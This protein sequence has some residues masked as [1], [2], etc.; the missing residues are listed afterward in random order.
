MKM[1]G[2]SLVRNTRNSGESLQL[3]IAS[4]EIIPSTPYRKSVDCNHGEHVVHSGGKYGSYLLVPTIAK[5]KVCIPRA[6]SGLM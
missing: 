6:C 1:N 4:D 5:P 2:P 3:V